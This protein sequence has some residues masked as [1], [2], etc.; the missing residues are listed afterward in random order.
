MKGEKKAVYSPNPKF[1]DLGSFGPKASGY[2]FIG[3]EIRP[4]S[5]AY[6]SD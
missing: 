5:K 1:L 4:A 2:V 6:H 3:T